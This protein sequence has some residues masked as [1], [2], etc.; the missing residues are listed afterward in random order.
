MAK[1]KVYWW[2]PIGMFL[3]L[4]IFSALPGNHESL[5]G[6]RSVA[7]LFPATVVVFWFLAWLSYKVGSCITQRGLR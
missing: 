6:Y 2:L 1:L 7:P 3:A 5:V 4:G